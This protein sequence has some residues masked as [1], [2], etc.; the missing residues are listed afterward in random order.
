MN[1]QLFDDD[2]PLP[3]G[4]GALLLSGFAL[5][6]DTALLAAIDAVSA[7]APPRT[8]WTPGG[9]RMSVQTTSC[10]RW[11]WISDNA[12]YRY[13]ERDPAT[14][15]V[16]PAMPE[17]L[18]RLAV[19]AAARAGYHGFQPDTC[20]IN[21]YVP[22]ARMGLHQDRN[23]SDFSQPIVSVS[24]GLPIIFQFGGMRRSDPT[25]RVP[26]AHGD[27]LVWGG[28]TRLAFHGVLTLKAGVHPLTG[29]VRINLTF[30]RAH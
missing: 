6:A 23:E 28:P 30:R 19:N 7:Q 8:L 15:R 11:G 13:A 20:L 4:D 14:G 22:G 21:R 3:I 25:R 26:L 24:L 29:A 17:P 2:T 5:N 16:W 12:G 27:V 10:G 9:H 1:H 18:R